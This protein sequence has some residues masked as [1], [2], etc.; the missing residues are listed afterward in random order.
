[1]TVRHRG[2]AGPTPGRH[3]FT[4]SKMA[5]ITKGTMTSVSEDVGQSDLL[6]VTGG[7]T[8][9]GPWTTGSAPPSYTGHCVPLSALQ[10]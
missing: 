8:H 7:D 9:C 3:C 4:P 5:V 6:H 10:P 2:S 1:M